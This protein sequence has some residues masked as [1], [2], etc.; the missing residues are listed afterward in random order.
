MWV[1]RTRTKICVTAGYLHR[2]LKPGNLLLAA[3]GT[4]KLADFGLACSREGDAV[5]DM[6]AV[7]TRWYR[8]PELLLSARA[9]SAAVDMWA[10]GCILAELLGARAAVSP[11][12]HMSFKG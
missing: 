4:L 6:P 9:H 2:D 7:A 3:D 11:F 8:A 12:P 5:V 10:V 1:R